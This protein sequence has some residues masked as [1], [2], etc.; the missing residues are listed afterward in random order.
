MRGAHAG[1]PQLRGA[2]WPVWEDIERALGPKKRV[3]ALRLAFEMLEN[4]PT[5]LSQ[6]APEAL[7]RGAANG[8]R[9]RKTRQKDDDAAII[10]IRCGATG[11]RRKELAR[12]PPP[13]RNRSSFRS[14]RGGR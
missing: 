1:A 13:P 3:C 12:S 6:G 10:A 8:G 5:V 14:G 4:E 11:A 9:G 7:S 2:T